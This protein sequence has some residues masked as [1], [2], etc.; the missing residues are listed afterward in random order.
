MS[1]EFSLRRLTPTERRAIRVS[2]SSRTAEARLVERA[3][4]ITLAAQAGNPSQI[5]RELG[6]SRRTR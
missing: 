3:R 1:P 4:I 2:A 5:A 6:I